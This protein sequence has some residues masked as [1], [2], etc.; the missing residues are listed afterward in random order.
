MYTTNYKI[1]YSEKEYKK[2]FKQLINQKTNKAILYEIL[3][4]KEYEDKDKIEYNYELIC[5]YSDAFEL[6]N[7][8][9]E[10]IFKKSKK[11]KKILS[12]DHNFCLIYIHTR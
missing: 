4:Q 5:V 11:F 6:Q 8:F 12:D 1:L 2:E 3:K 10:T 9:Y 7:C